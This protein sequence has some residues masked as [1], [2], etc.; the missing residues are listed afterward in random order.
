MY[1]KGVNDIGSAHLS[2]NN[3]SARFVLILLSTPFIYI[4]N[5]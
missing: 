3:P 4:Q 1:Q 5:R 2:L